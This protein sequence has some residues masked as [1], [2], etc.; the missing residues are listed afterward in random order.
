MGPYNCFNDIT[1]KHLLR[2]FK[3]RQKVTRK[4]YYSELLAKVIIRLSFI[5]GP[6]P[7]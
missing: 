7:Y 5:L 3:P 4:I 6:L 1:A 2:H